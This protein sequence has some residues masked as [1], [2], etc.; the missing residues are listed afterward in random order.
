MPPR[1]QIGAMMNR[2]TNFQESKVLNSLVIHV[3]KSLETL[4]QL[5][6]MLSRLDERLRGGIEVV[7]VV[8]GSPDGSFAF[9][10]DS[11]ESTSFSS[12]LVS[13]SRNFGAFEAIKTGLD[14]ANGNFTAVMSADLQEPIELIERFYEVLEGG[15]FDVAVGSRESRIDPWFSKM[16]SSS[17]WGLYR[18]FIQPEMPRG[19]VDVFAINRRVRD[20]IVTASESNT[21][22]VGYLLW[23]G[24][25][26]TEIK[27]SRLQ[28]AAGSS[29]WTVRK[30]IR[31]FANSV[32]S[33]SSLPIS[34]IL[35]VGAFGSIAT[36]V[37]A[38][39]V[40]MA[41]L[42]N[43]IEVPGYTAQ[44]LVQ[45]FSTGSLLF[46]IGL[47]GTYAWRT[48]ENSKQRPGSIVMSERKFGRN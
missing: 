20:Q 16:L 19:G 40:F 43:G 41:W 36:F 46:A 13:L 31:Y 32:F 17:Y 24:F 9:L 5:L 30:K 8:D 10:L 25:R 28:R 35:F 11:L 4:P 1:G 29:S 12:Q 47:V 37:V 14:L 33:F 39:V 21:S 42:T 26:R 27:Y 34:I 15:D 22:L 18:R 3:Y 48:Y 38:F 23:V 45:L 2:E 6:E 44:I 7:F